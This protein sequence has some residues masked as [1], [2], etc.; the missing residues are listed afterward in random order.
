MK[1]ILTSLLC[2]VMVVCMMPG[3]AWADIG[4]VNEVSTADAL[5]S[6]IANGGTVRLTD[7][8]NLGTLQSAA[9]GSVTAGLSIDANATVILDLNGHTIQASLD[10]NKDNYSK[11]HVILNNGNLTIE[12]SSTN[13]SGKIVNTNENS[14]ACTRT[15]KNA[16]AG[17]LHIT[18]GTIESASAVGLLN[19][20]VCVIKGDHTAVKSV[21]NDYTGGWDNACAAIENRE[22][23][24]L[25]IEGGTFSSISEAALFC[26]GSNQTIISGGSFSGNAK[27]GD[28]NGNADPGLIEI[29]GGT[30]STAVHA[31]Y[32]GLFCVV[33]KSGE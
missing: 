19:L 10:T 12:D 9:D 28:L 4:S 8:I 3:M 24:S 30:W 2:V 23:G 31:D 15:V 27:Y 11:V 18:G 6:A 25:T 7:D 32:L 17:T 22:N 20:G 13:H 5:K 21:K 33:E 1:K 29:K 16:A 26:D 14:Y